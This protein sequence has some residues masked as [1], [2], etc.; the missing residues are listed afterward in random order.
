M[1]YKIKNEKII[2]I[3]VEKR[4]QKELDAKYSFR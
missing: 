3:R 2:I 1:I 4:E